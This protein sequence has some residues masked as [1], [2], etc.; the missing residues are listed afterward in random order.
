MN[1]IDTYKPHN[2]VQELV[3]FTIAGF[4]MKDRYLGFRLNFFDYVVLKPL[5]A[6]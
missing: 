3:P 2:N 1:D 5:V 4:N 6:M